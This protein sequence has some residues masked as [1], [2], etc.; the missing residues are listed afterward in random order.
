MR[1]L[2]VV[3]MAVA[4][5]ASG[6]AST[7]WAQRSNT[8]QAALLIGNAKY[9]DSDAPLVSPIEDTRA[10]ASELRAKGYAVTLGENLSKAEMA[11]TAEKFVGGIQPGAVV[12]VYFSGYGV[13]SGRKNYLIPVDAQIWTEPDVQKIGL[14]LDELLADIARRNPSGTFVALDGAHRNPF[15][16]RFRSYSNGL[17]PF[18]S[19]TQPAVIMYSTGPGTV[20]RAV[21]DTRSVF[22]TEMVKLI[23]SG[24]AL[25]KAGFDRTRAAV[26]A[27]TNNVQ[28]PWVFSSVKDPVAPE[29]VAAVSPQPSPVAVAPPAPSV[30]A[31]PPAVAVTPP[32]AAPPVVVAPATPAAVAPAAPAAVAPA[33]TAKPADTAF[34][35]YDKAKRIGSREALEEFLSRN[36]S[37]PL[38]ELARIDLRQIDAARAPAQPPSTV[39]AA[40]PIPPPATEARKPLI[41]PLAYS[42]SDDRM[43]MDLGSAIQ[44][45]PDDLASLYTRGQLL[46]MHYDFTQALADF[47]RVLQISP[48]DVEALNNRCWIRAI[49]DQVDGA[50]S[51]CNAALKLRPNFLDALDSRGFVHLKIGLP[52]RAALDYEAALRINGKHP[53]ALYG[54]SLA[55]RRLGDTARAEGSSR[56][57]LAL[58]P[59]VAEEFVRFGVR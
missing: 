29:V 30:A 15:E 18:A 3:Y 48:E 20:L 17:A 34:E 11:A 1:P 59:G 31:A 53:S 8:P 5:V 37:G 28:V 2:A 27:S 26:A 4:L 41:Q 54:L 58:N 42:A 21:G 7:A 50:L 49:V 13:Q 55:R 12:L 51:D 24:D 16:R 10:L 33:Q 6:I 25:S 45:N 23:G 52:R 43:R 32:P 38:A 44:R 39:I 36:G 57:A 14:G 47:D 56:A 35:Q 22:G 19:L 46:A 40:L 9:P